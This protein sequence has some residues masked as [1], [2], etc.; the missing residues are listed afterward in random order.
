MTMFVSGRFLSSSACQHVEIS[1]SLS[2]EGI[3]SARPNTVCWAL[4]SDLSQPK[5]VVQD[6]PNLEGLC[7]QL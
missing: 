6:H 7:P 2:L 1:L 4:G 5:R 3:P